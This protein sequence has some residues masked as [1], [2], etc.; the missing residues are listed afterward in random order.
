M[1]GK[2]VLITGAT[3]GIGLEAAVALARKGATVV[4][5]ARDTVKGE[6]A[7][8]LV[9]TRSGNPDVECLAADLSLMSGVRSLAIRFLAK[10]RRLDVLVNNAGLYLDRRETTPEGNEMMLAVNLLAPFLLTNYLAR[11]LKKGAPSRVIMVASTAHR[12]AKLDLFDI[13]GEGTRD[14]PGKMYGRTKKLLV[15]LTHEFSRRLEGE[16]VAVNSMC[17]GGVSTGIWWKREKVGWKQ[18]LFRKL[19]LPILKTPAQGA[20]L[21]VYLASSDRVSGVSG[22]YFETPRHVRFLPWSERRSERRSSRDTYNPESERRL[23]GI[24]SGLAGWKGR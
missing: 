17:P 11:A 9:A 6:K 13:Q 1:K 22:R 8:E 4:I 19:V 15:M 21:I 14:N 20:R 12:G 5:T 18:R 10:H 7:R 16:G 24:V 3:S 2:V 23:W